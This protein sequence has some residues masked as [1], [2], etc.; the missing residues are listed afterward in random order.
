MR[1][2]VLY[3][4]RRVYVRR[5]NVGLKPSANNLFHLFKI[6]E[7][8]IY[9]LLSTNKKLRHFAAL[10]VAFRTIKS[11]CT[12][13][14]FYFMPPDKNVPSRSENVADTRMACL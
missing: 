5:S 12:K 13:R 1:S 7:H 8:F 9:L 10:V 3:D 2:S 4:Y 6:I 14:T 11:L